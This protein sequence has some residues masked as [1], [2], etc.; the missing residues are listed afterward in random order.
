MELTPAVFKDFL[1]NSLSN[2]IPSFG[3]DEKRSSFVRRQCQLSTLTKKSSAVDIDGTFH[4]QIYCK[5]IKIYILN[6]WNFLIFQ[7]FDF[8]KNF[9][10]K[11]AK[12]VFITKVPQMSFFNLVC[13]NQYNH[14]AVVAWW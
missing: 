10:N 13:Y 14:P 5:N 1:L 2:N 12:Q 6:N 8:L 3:G 7:N 11:N 9:L 4:Y